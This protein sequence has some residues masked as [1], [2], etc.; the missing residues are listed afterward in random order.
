MSGSGP[1]API[2]AGVWQSW[3]P[4]AVTRYLPRAIDPVALSP[5]PALAAAPAFGAVLAPPA[6][7]APAPCV[8][9]C[10]DTPATM[11]NPADAVITTSRCTDGPITS[12]LHIIVPPP[13][14]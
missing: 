6:P 5:V 2:F 12:L 3:Q 11:N 4:M 7:V 10:A 9:L 14:T 13:A 8:A 1:F